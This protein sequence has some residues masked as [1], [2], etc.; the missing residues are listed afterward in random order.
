VVDVVLDFWDW[1]FYDW[2]VTGV[3]SVERREKRAIEREILLQFLKQEHKEQQVRFLPL[4]FE[5]QDFI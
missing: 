5:F 3:N 1:I 2:A 4:W